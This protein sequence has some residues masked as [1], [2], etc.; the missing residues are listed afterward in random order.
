M[1]LSKQQQI[2]TNRT[3]APAVKIFFR[4]EGK[5]S[6]LI[7]LNKLKGGENMTEKEHL[8]KWLSELKEEQDRYTNQIKNYRLKRTDL[9]I[10]RQVLQELMFQHSTESHNIKDYLGYDTVAAELAKLNSDDHGQEEI[11]LQ[12]KLYTLALAIQKLENRLEHM[13]TPA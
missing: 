11:L 4:T 6:L 1:K 2:M 12:E 10:K 7:E 9:S 5:I 13:D 8:E 3:A